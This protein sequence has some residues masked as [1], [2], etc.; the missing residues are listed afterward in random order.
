MK[1]NREMLMK[2]LQELS[3]RLYDLALYLDTHSNDTSAL[4]LYN[5]T[6]C[7]YK[8][9]VSNFEKLYG[10]I[11]KLNIDETANKWDWINGPWPWE[12]VKYEEEC[13]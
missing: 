6:L 9:M 2:E 12:C 10:P 4:A 5:Q 13:K 8:S 1:R 7:K 11:S 3:F